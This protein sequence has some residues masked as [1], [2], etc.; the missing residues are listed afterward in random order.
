MRA[1]PRPKNEDNDVERA[2][3]IDG[4]L[5]MPGGEHRLVLPTI[6]FDRGKSAVFLR[7]TINDE[8][9]AQPLVRHIARRGKKHPQALRHARSP[10]RRLVA[11]TF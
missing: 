11:I 8:I 9:G 3:R 2:R 5:K 7:Q 10:P 6:G 4:V 1:E